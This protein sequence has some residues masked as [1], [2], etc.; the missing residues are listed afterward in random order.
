MPLGR[1]AD[2]RVVAARPSAPSPR[3]R[4][5]VVAVP[6][7]HDYE[8]VA[9]EPQVRRAAAP[10]VGL[11]RRRHPRRHRSRTRWRRVETELVAI[12]DAA[13]PLRHPGAD[14]RA[15]SRRS[16]PTPTPPARS[17]PRRSP[18]RSSGRPRR[19]S[20][21]SPPWRG[22]SAARASR[23]PLDRGGSGRR[24][25]RR[26]SGRRRC[27]R[28]STA[29]SAAVAEATDEAML[30][31]AAGG[32]VLIHP[33]PA[34]NLKVTTPLDLRLAELLLADA[35][36]AR[37]RTQTRAAGEAEL[38]D[39]ERDAEAGGAE[40][41]RRSRCRR[42]RRRAGSRAARIIGQL[43]RRAVA[44]QTGGARLGPSSRW[45]RRRRS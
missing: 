16:P 22:E 28:R 17:P 40:Q 31:E 2:G 29:R 27:A 37:S 30:V 26:S 39:A 18:T 1:P 20:R 5:I 12:H 24:R 41:P 11:A 43:L 21:R 32:R 15:W 4:A 23:R 7:G 3:V 42:R 10:S 6:P 14:R 45:R 9:D 13:R 19:A 44:R 33:A 25:R 8:P 34:E 36:Q 35:L 38:A